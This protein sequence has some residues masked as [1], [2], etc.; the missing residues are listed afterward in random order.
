MVSLWNF[1][2]N[3]VVYKVVLVIVVGCFFVLKL[4]SRMLFLVFILGEI[5]YKIEE[6]LL[7]VFFIFFVLWEDVDMFI[8]D[9]WFKFLIFIGLG[10]IGWDMKVCVGKKKVIID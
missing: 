3:F 5:L 4:V 7:G 2:F 6:L 9:E 10:L 1:L 8:V